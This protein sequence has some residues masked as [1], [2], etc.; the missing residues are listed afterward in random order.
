MGS[1]KITYNCGKCFRAITS[2][3]YSIGC[4]GCKGWFHKGECSGLSL[5]SMKQILKE[6]ASTGYKWKCEACSKLTNNPTLTVSSNTNLKASNTGTPNEIPPKKV[7]IEYEN[8]WLAKIDFLNMIIVEKD[9]KYNLLLENKHLLEDKISYQ[10]QIIMDLRKQLST[11]A[12]PCSMEEQ[13]PCSENSSIILG[14]NKNPSDDSI[15]II[16]DN[17]SSTKKQLHSQQDPN[18]SKLQ[19]QSKQKLNDHV[20]GNGSDITGLSASKPLKWF[21]ITRISKSVSSDCFNN[22][23]KDTLGIE[24]A[25]CVKLTQNKFEESASNYLSYKV[26]V[27]E[28]DIKKIMSPESWPPG[29]LVKEFTKN[30]RNKLKPNDRICVLGDFNLSKVVW[31]MDADNNEIFIPSNFTFNH[32]HAFTDSLTSLNLFQICGIKIEMIDL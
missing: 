30:S 1:P 16:D 6:Q 13:M 17:Y 29:L 22:H 11:S 31:S 10:N 4:C 21:F 7:H 9:T 5:E 28:C 19:Q 18:P 12:N 27:P 23:V 15:L 8:E 14:K 20:I 24:D 3:S 25:L 26:G 32:E 2:N